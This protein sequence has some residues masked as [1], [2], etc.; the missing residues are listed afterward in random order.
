MEGTK[1]KNGRKKKEK[2]FSLT[3]STINARLV[4]RCEAA[5]KEIP[6]RGG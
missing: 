1:K 6:L 5:K 4:L 2:L 3:R